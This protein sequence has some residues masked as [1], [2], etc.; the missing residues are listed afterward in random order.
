MRTHK[1][2]PQN[3]KFHNGK[4]LEID[5][6]VLTLAQGPTTPLVAALD[7]SLAGQEGSYLCDAVVVPDDEMERWAVDDEVARK[8]WEWDEGLIGEKF[9]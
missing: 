1:S 2:Q 7:P 3:Q 4:A 8:L 6:G 5:S 9:L